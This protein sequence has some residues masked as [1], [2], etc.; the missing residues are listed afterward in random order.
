MEYTCGLCKDLKKNIIGELPVYFCRK[1]SV[2]IPQT[3]DENKVTFHRIPMNC[4]RSSREAHKSE[5]P[6]A[7]KYWVKLSNK[8]IYESFEKAK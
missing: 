8:S 7:K 4:P 1:T 3:T 6:A 5:K 2:I